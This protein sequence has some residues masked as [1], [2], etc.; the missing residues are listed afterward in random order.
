MVYNVGCMGLPGVEVALEELTCLVLG[1]MVME[2]KVS[3]IAD[4]LFIGGNTPEEL[5]S[6]FHLVLQKFL[7]NNKAQC[8]QNYNIS[9]GSN[10]PRL[11][12]EC[13]T[14]ESKFTQVTCIG[15]L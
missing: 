8:H 3:K 2:G 5:L 7:T 4:D 11:V 6:N 14:V 15:H 9:Q 1:D 13:W 12:M 10:H